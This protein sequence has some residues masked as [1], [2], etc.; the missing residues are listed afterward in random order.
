MI[1]DDMHQ[2]SQKSQ[3]NKD[4]QSHNV[5]NRAIIAIMTNDE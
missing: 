4:W 2:I 1:K 3:H 5:Q